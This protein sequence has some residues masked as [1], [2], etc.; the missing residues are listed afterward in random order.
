MDNLNY[1]VIGNGR[2]AALVST[3]GSIDWCCLP[4]F[5]SSSAFAKI[6]DENKGG[7]FGF[8]VDDS[9]KITQKYILQTNLLL[10]R[11]E[12]SE[13]AFEVIDFM[14]RYFNGNNKHHNPPDIVR[15]I[16]WVFGQPRFRVNYDPKLNYA[17][18][19]TK[20]Y[21]EGNYIK[22]V[23]V[24]GIYDSLYL[25][26]S[27][28]KE[29]ILQKN[30]V[31]VTKDEFFLVS[32][33]QKILKQNVERSY[34][35]ME[36]TKVYWLNWVEKL[37]KFKKYNDEIIRSSLVL[38]LLSYDKSGAILA[39]LTTSLPETIG[40]V[41]NWDYRFCWIRDASMVIKVLT[42]LGQRDVAWRY[43][44]FIINSIPIKNEKVQIMYGL[45]GEKKL[46][47]QILGH[48]DGYNGSKPVRVGN[49]A[50]KQ[51]QNDVFGILI[52]VIYQQLQ[53]IGATLEES[54]ALW[55]ITRTVLKTVE[56]NWQ[57]PDRG[58]WELRTEK[59]HFTFSKLLCWVAFDRGV[60]IANMLRRQDYVRKWTKIRDRIAK[61]IHTRAWNER[62]G[63]FTQAYES[64]D[65]DASTLL[66]EPY[67]FIEATDPKYIK[68]VNIIEQELSHN[69]L[70]FRYKN[71]DDFGV[72]KSSFTICTFWLINAL[73]K[74]GQKE[75]AE[76]MFGKLLSYSNH[77]GLYSEDID[78]ESKRLLGNFPQAYS[79]LALIETAINISGGV[80]SSEESIIEA[81]H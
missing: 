32:Y 49:A 42:N 38:K 24:Q 18:N 43:M 37:V 41:R 12:N 20:S 68:T 7:S 13:G 79:H 4:E 29:D 28:S 2:S 65:L 81:I 57:K 22:S 3:C 14:P 55:T 35:K 67:G 62:V 52:D 66:M 8:D 71:R 45:R 9:Y 56:N 30:E 44:Q 34:L 21:I 59:Q 63:A 58:I 15:Y 50:Y 69:G 33:N 5:D 77:L 75:K 48:L 36:R 76:A 1:G 80:V 16:R 10:T 26:S 17:K 54:E 6:L 70:M 40:E 25:Y 74:T 61:N 19:A 53:I 73:H 23:T 11:F 39:A 47:E 31:T 64:D 27:L 46:T 78:F 51:K 60:K 72:P